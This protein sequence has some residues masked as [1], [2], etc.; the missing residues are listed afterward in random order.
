M[1]KEKG[2]DENTWNGSLFIP[3]FLFIGLGLG[4]YLGTLKNI[5]AFTLIGL[6]LGFL[7]YTITNIRRYRY[8]RI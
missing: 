3:T 6:G 1:Q 5:F 8:Q 7:F 4:I 2:H